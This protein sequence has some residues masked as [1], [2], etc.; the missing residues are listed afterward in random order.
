[1]DEIAA[2]FGLRS[3][4]GAFRL[5]AALEERG[6]IR[7]IPNRARSIELVDQKPLV[8]ISTGELI[9][10]LERRGFSVAGQDHHEAPSLTRA[11]AVS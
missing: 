7:R 10:E 1:M 11:G 8:S 2:K 6:F 3:K 9:R 5:V 4:S